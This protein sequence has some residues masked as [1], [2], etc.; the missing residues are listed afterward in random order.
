MAGP[1]PND[2][3]VNILLVDDQPA[4]LLAYEV[5]LR[6][7]GENLLKANS[8]REAL[9]TL[10]RSEVAI[11]LMDVSM[12]E[13][14][15]FEL[16]AMVRNHPRFQR[17][18]I[19]FVSAIHFSEVDFLR[20]YR[21]GAVDYVSVPVIPEVLRAKVKVFADLYRKTRELETLNAGL[22]ARVK[23]RTAELEATAAR[24]RESEQRRSLA[25]AAGQMGSWDWDLVRNDIQWDDGQYTIIGA[26]RASFPI[27]VANLR[28]VIHPADWSRL[29]GLI[30]GLSAE[31]PACQAEFRIR[32]RDGELCWCFGTAAATIGDNGQMVR[33]S[34]VTIDITDR[35]RTEEQQA[36][37]VREV[38]HR[39]KNVLAVVQSIVRLSRADTV[40]G[41]VSAIEGR[42]KAL[43][44]VHG[45]LAQSRWEG[46]DLRRLVEDELSPYAT[47]DGGTISINGPSLSLEPA[48]AQAM[49]L[50]LHELSTNAA[51]Y[52]ALSAPGGGID[53]RW[54][55]G[56]RMLA[57]TWTERGGPPAA[58]PG[59]P[60]FGMKVIDRSVDA[61]L[62]GRVDFKWRKDGLVCSLT[63]PLT[64]S[65]ASRIP[66]PPS[67]D[68]DAA[69][70]SAGRGRVLLVE[71][72]ALVAIMMSDLLAGLGF[73][74]V[75]PIASVAQAM[76]PARDGELDAALLDVTLGNERIYP[77]AE[78]LKQRGIPFCF[79]TGYGR[80]GIDPRFAN[81]PVL[82]K[83]VDE[84]A[85]ADFLGRAIKRVGG[86]AVPSPA[87]PKRSALQ[88]ERKA[89][90][91][92]T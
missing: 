14:D 78:I 61:Q 92:D 2:D 33:I 66:D 55:E 81:M 88:F 64:G 20:G 90:A 12:P 46:T 17:T 23:D 73:T 34:G 89:L 58:R 71:D 69:T 80:D 56:D 44:R 19:I 4:K 65:D 18:A 10:L 6:D 63:V 9:E 32:R 79:L 15:G 7:T 36:L 87:Q 29:E 54:S 43:S 74:V 52:G 26:E 8:A 68:T 53:V 22:E 76:G 45:I 82:Q 39:A 85:L 21:M 48:T 41:Y 28:R 91:P 49:A 67:D 27:T 16:A 47:S 83:P 59:N 51:K 13:L 31:Q 5:M 42:I 57:L 62:G 70:E 25:L 86:D 37:L 72:E 3:K 40:E 35:R 77:V 84:T 11:V 60:G 1:A 30:R 75:G 38:D 50:A 24:L